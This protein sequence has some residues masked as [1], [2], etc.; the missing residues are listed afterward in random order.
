MTALGRW[1]AIA[2]AVL[3]LGAASDPGER[4]ADPA[5]EARARALFKE[6]RCLV[7]QNESIDASNAELAQDLRAIVRQEV[8]QGRSDVEVRRFLTDRYGEYVLLKPRFSWANAA[9]WLF[10]L[11]VVLGGAGLLVGRWR[12]P[13]AESAALSSEETEALA[14]LA[15]DPGA[16]RGSAS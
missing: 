13:Q 14:R 9:L 10:P 15:D 7:C 2:C 5:Q 4:L 8:A 11:L 16:D 12:S 1:L 3:C 6:V